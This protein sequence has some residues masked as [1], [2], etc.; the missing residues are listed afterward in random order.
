MLY[1]LASVCASTH[2]HVVLMQ[3]DTYVAGAAC[4]RGD[5][6]LRGAYSLFLV[7][8]L[9][10]SFGYCCC[11]FVLVELLFCVCM[12]LIETGEAFCMHD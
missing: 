3:A 5:V 6:A 8:L 9:V 7:D 10:C 11:S 1:L 12:K 2:Q 4:E